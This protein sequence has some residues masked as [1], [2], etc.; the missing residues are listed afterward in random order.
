MNPLHYLLINGTELLALCCWW[1]GARHRGGAYRLLGAQLLVANAVELGAIAMGLAHLPVKPLYNLY[2]LVESALLG[3]MLVRLDGRLLPAV[4]WAGPALLL[5]WVLETALLGFTG[6]FHIIY[7]ILGGL[8]LC[9]LSSVVLW[10]LAMHHQG[11]LHQVP[12]FWLLLGMVVYFGGIAPV[13]S[14]YNY[15]ESRADVMSNGLYWIVR[16]LCAAR[17]LCVAAA[18]LLARPRTPAPAAA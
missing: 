3:W 9:A 14:A 2:L 15:F 7:L 6:W 1:W 12:T 11:P 18:C 10:R 4:R 17:Y 13:F 16:A 8:T 5:A